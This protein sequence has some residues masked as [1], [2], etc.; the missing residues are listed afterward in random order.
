M[1]I[2][3][4]ATQGE[5]I[6]DLGGMLLGL[7]AFKKT[8]AYKKNE[9]IG[10]LTQ[11]QRYFLGYALGWMYQVKK[12]R[13]ASRVK[14]DVH[15]PAKERVNGPVVNIPEFY[16]AFGIKPGDKMYRADSLRVRIW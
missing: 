9:K 2:N 5:N 11:V 6:A 16:E 8:A 1:H 14:T 12:D 10:G 15:A 4:N 3:G 13:L 7:D